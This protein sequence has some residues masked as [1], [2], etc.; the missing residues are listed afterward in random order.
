VTGR[1]SL[2]LGALVGPFVDLSREGGAVIVCAPCPAPA[3]LLAFLF[4]Q[5][6]WRSAV[7]CAF[8]EPERWS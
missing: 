2:D 8:A 3:D 6:V 5:R 7:F 1:R 4:F